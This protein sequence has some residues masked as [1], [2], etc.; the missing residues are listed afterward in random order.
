MPSV[1][2]DLRPAE[3][4]EATVDGAFNPVEPAILYLNLLGVGVVLEGTAVLGLLMP[5]V[6]PDLIGVLSPFF[7]S[8][9]PLIPD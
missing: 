1:N 9:F 4:L 3:I 7:T 5:L 8:S 6:T 2:L